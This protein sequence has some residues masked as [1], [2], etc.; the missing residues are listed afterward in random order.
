MPIYEYRC[1]QCRRKLSVLSRTFDPPASVRCEA[2]GSEDT[3][4][5]LSTFSFHKSLESK[6]RDLD[7]QYDQMVEDAIASTPEADPYRYI[8]KMIP[9]E[10]AEE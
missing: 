3:T 2:C 5:L 1:Q 10:A 9:F 7:P 8:N 6:L 4:R